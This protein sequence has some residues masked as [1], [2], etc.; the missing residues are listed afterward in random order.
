MDFVAIDVETANAALSSICQ[1][2]IATFRDGQQVDSWV[3]LVNPQ[4]YFDTLNVSI[5]GIDEDAVAGAPSWKEVFPQ[6]ASRLSGK[7]TVCHMPFD[8][9][10]LTKACARASVSP[11]DCRWLD[12]AMVARRTW[13]ELSQS[14]YGLSNVASRLGIS[15]RAHDAL[16]DARCA[17]LVMLRAM[18]ESGLDLDN[19]L[20]RVRKPIDPQSGQ[21]REGNSEGELFGEVF[22]VTGS[23]SKSQ[24][25]VE[26]LAQAAGCRVDPR[27]TKHT[28]LLM[29]G[30]Q[31]IGKLNG[32]KKSRNHRNAEAWIQKGRPIRIL[33]ESD[34]EQIVSR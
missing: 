17:G 30:D 3:T 20:T 26:D 1:V 15:Y 31:D 28:T 5:H 11:C 6:I 13:R 33:G 4:D 24:R 16:E 10:A 32:H 9:T 12:S 27:V 19:W 8:K 18:A 2:G 34:F 7:I 21:V 29:V 14:G 22:V 25:E 23:F